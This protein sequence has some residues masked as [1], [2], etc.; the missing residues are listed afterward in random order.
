LPQGYA[1]H[2]KSAAAQFPMMARTAAS[3]AM[4]TDHI[5]PL[6]WVG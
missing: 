2:N 6:M 5:I 3:Y 1:E 4:R